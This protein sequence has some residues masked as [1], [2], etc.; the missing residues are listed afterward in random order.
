VPEKYAL[1]CIVIINDV[2]LP[3]RWFIISYEK[4]IA[5]NISLRID[6]ALLARIDKTARSLDRHRT[7][8]VLT[9]VE[10]Y[11]RKQEQFVASVERAMSEAD[12]ADN[13]VPHEELAAAAS[14]GTKN[15]RQ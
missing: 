5:M 11:L 13:L 1:Y 14:A 6:D 7:W 15:R 4:G 8:V 10:E 9:A 3:V 2:A 12:D